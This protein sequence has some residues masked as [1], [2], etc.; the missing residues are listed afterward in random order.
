MMMI[1][2]LVSFMENRLNSEVAT[3]MFN[4]VDDLSAVSVSFLL[5]IKQNALETSSGRKRD[6]Q[7][8][9]CFT[10]CFD[11]LEQHIIYLQRGDSAH[12]LLA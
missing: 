10:H 2:Y 9:M 11:V 1:Q 6:G 5:V 12:E 4:L 8:N 7:E 3:M